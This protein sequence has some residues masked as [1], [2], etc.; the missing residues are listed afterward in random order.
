M[1]TTASV[2]Y[3]KTQV[4]DVVLPIIIIVITVLQ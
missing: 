4:M 2:N 1:F 3:S